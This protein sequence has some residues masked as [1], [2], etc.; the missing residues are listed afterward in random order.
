VPQLETPRT[1]PR[2]SRTILPAVLAILVVSSQGLRSGGGRQYCAV[3]WRAEL[4]F[5]F[6]EA[7]RPDLH[8]LAT[9]P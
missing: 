5:D 7:A 8:M 9:T 4:L 1:T 6:G 3:R 2:W